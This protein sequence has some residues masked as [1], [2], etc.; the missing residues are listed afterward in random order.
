M[1]VRPGTD[2]D[3]P[4]L[5]SLVRR[6]WDFEGIEGFAALRMELVLQHLLAEPRLGVVL[7]AEADGRLVGYLAAVTMLSIEHQGPMAE[8]DE[9]FVLPEARA[10]GVGGR[11]LAAAETALAARGCVRLQLQLAL[12]NAPGRAFYEHRGYTPREGYRLFDKPLGADTYDLERFVQ[13]Q[14]P[15]IERVRAE[16]AAGEKASHWMWFIFP[17]LRGL[18]ASA[19]ARRF[20]LSGLAEARAYLAHP[21]LGARLRECAQLVLAVERRTV[22]E[23][24][25]Y[26]D[27]LKFHSCLTLFAQAA[28]PHA[29]PEDRVFDE[30]LAKYYG[31]EADPKT[32]ELLTSAS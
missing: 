12:A 18:G 25:G 9:F 27:Y 22:E 5:L 31:G 26:P 2:R 16:L 3:I 7:V 30:A 32:L 1:N 17:Q 20:G 29:S 19:T 4:E 11:L 10:R 14:Q 28:G 8:I 6:Y 24:F 23:I 13:A 21:L 15:L